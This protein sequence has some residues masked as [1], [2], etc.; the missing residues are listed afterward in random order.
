MAWGDNAYGQ[1]GNGSATEGG[2]VCL[3][4][5]TPV[6]G[7]SDATQ[8]SGG[9][10]TLALHANGTVTSW[11]YNALGQLGDGT[12]TESYTP[13]SVSGLTN[14][15]AVDAGHEHNL[16][17][18]ANGTVMAW[19]DNYNGEL[20][21]GS[22]ISG[23]G[24]EICETSP[25]SKVPVQVPGLSNVVAI[26]AGY[27][28]S[29]AL[30]ADGTVMAWGFDNYGQFGDGTGIQT[31]CECN[32]HP[33]PVPGV[34]GAIAISVGED[35]VVAL[36][37]NGAVS[38]WG[39]NADGQIGNGT[40]IE[41][42]P[43]ICL[44]LGALGVGGLSGPTAQV[45]AGGY[46]SLALLGG[47]NAQSWGFNSD[48]ELGNG[49]ETKGGCVCVPTPGA[50]SE[51]SGTRSI[52]AGDS[53]TLALL[54]DGDVRAWG[55]NGNGQVGDGTK[56]DRSAPVPVSGVSG[57]SAVTTGDNTSFALIGPSHALTVSLAGA[58]TGNVG[59]P[60]GIIC[61]AVNCT[62]RFPDSQ[63]Q[64]L[65]AEPA[66][67]TGF[68]GFTGG[69]TG[70]GTCQVKMDG[71]KT[72]T[73]TF[74]PPKGTMITKA[75]IKQGKKRTRVARGK[76]TA[77]AIFSFSAPGALTGYQCMLV[78]PKPKKGKKPLRRFS[79]CA[80]PKRYKKLHKG[81]YTFKVRAR[82]I[83]GVDA[84]PAQRSS[85]SSANRE[86]AEHVLE[87]LPSVVGGDGEISALIRTR[88]S[89]CMRR[90]SPSARLLGKTPA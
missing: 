73:A 19:G 34:S 43:P 64:I 83:L 70:T 45:A 42:S 47:G 26:A 5:P 18:L 49:S 10:H 61:P 44:C 85:R 66:P 59:G 40:N 60:D 86:V 36:R 41:V 71:D 78:K 8:I 23:G 14:V 76:P 39:E 58:G 22:S 72:V 28:Y 68:A 29:F 15:V 53:H 32:A 3:P 24:P 2:C 37:G 1:I 90:T 46:H 35:H 82:N 55:Y 84:K 87:Q 16:A 89:D 27:F 48:G 67:G 9:I 7:L 12:T 65:R 88:W 38:A 13:V 62:D 51:I 11:G 52:A 21:L 6:S 54:S 81:R 50:V 25:C 31:G 77:K 33:V 74:G 4:D 20:G 63:V 57:A 80:S 79:S 69:C 75:K 17:L 30:L 56:T